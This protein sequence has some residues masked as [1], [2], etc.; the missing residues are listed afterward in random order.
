LRLLSLVAGRL[1]ALFDDGERG[2]IFLERYTIATTTVLVAMQSY[3]IAISLEG[4]GAVVAEPGLV[5]RLTTVLTLTAGVLFLVWLAGQMTA[6]G[7][8]NGV[9]LVIAAGIVNALPRD[10]AVVIEGMRLGIFASGAVPAV[11]VV[12][13]ILAALVVVA[14]RSRRRIAIEFAERR[15][16]AGLLPLQT[17]DLAVKLNPAGIMPTYLAVLVLNVIV[18]AA[19]L[20]ALS[21]EA[22]GWADQVRAALSYGTLLHLVVTAALLVLF[23]FVYTAF[24]CDPEQMAARLAAFGGALPGVAPGEATEAHLDRTIAR[25]TAFGAAYLV[26]VMLLPEVL[27]SWLGLPLVLGGVSTLVLVCVALDL[28]AEI[29]GYLAITP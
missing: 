7:I 12:T 27:G 16:G 11:V 14:E 8:G 29:R 23:T 2:R 24:V 26:V 22:G 20:A 4:V 21:G 3:G 10:I 18:I 5:F 1:R 19:F 9:A 13:A 28:A 6:R 17:V 25:T 15:V